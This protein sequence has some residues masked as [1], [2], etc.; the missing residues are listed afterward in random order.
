[1]HLV[2]LKKNLPDHLLLGSQNMF[3]ML[4][5]YPLS[6]QTWKWPIQFTMQLDNIQEIL[7]VRWKF[8][9]DLQNKTSVS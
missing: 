8:A 5:T 7:N 3:S 6:F 1:M 9:F 4:I 2:S